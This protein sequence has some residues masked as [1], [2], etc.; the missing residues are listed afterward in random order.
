VT[1]I[2]WALFRLGFGVTS[3]TLGAGGT[4]M[5]VVLGRAWWG[6]FKSL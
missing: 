4:A 2:P 3:A 5:L 1:A 6:R